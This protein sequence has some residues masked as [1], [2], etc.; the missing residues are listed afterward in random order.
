MLRAGSAVAQAGPGGRSVGGEEGKVRIACS[1]ARLSN[2]VG[3]LKPCAELRVLPLSGLVHE[4][5]ADA[6]RGERVGGSCPRGR[7]KRQS[8]A[9]GSIPV[10]LYSRSPLSTPN[11]AALCVAARVRSKRC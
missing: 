10:R 5:A 4:T 6:A 7:G 8:E 1:L 3:S 11:R 9:G 2:V